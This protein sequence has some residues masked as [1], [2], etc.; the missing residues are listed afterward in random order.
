MPQSASGRV[1]LYASVGPEL[2]QYD[3]DVEAAALVRRGAVNLPANVHYAWPHASGRYLYV[4]SS[5]SA[6]GTGSVGDKHHVTAFRIDPATGGLSPHGEPIP[7]PT[8][9]IHMTTDIPSD[10]LLVAF[11]N[12]SALRVYRVNPDA[13]PGDEVRQPEPIDA[14]IYGHQVR[15]SPDNRLAILVTRG[16]DAAA[17]KPEEPG[18]LKIFQYKDGLLTDEVSAAPNGGYG[19]GPRHLD[20]HPSKPWVYVSLERQN[21]LDMFEITNGKLSAA[22]VFRKETLAEPGNIRGRQAAG[23]VHVHPNGRFVYAANRASSTVQ[24]D[25]KSVFAGGENTFAV[26]EIDMTTGEPVP[27]QQVDTRGIHCRTFHIDPSGRM[28]VAAHI[29]ALP[30]REGA[31]IRTVPASLAV[32][33]IDNGG[34]LDFVRKYDVDV[35]SRTMFWMGMVPLSQ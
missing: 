23:T 28:L 25:G 32:F 30:V 19:F 4:A 16:H 21:K 1:A 27:I 31:A 10:H 11:S 18:A 13:T 35:G 9:P 34:K 6:P 3:V 12:P 33:R 14:G 22:P 24:V 15:V 20:F 29:M 26:Y 2:T 17:G 8:R 5:D 7:L